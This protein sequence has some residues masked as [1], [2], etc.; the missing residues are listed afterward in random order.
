MSPTSVVFILLVLSVLVGT[1]VYLI[2]RGRYFRPKNFEDLLERIRTDGATGLQIEPE[3]NAR[4]YIGSSISDRMYGIRYS[5]KVGNKQVKFAEEIEGSVMGL[6][7]LIA[8]GG[9]HAVRAFLLAV[10]RRDKLETNVPGLKVPIAMFSPH[11]YFSEADLVR[12]KSDARS[13]GLEA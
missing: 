3:V 10:D 6:A 1:A 7:G 5:G 13:L 4:I 2:D 8:D 12:L 11:S 9:E